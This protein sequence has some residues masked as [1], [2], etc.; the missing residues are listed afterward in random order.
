MKRI[1]LLNIAEKINS[2]AN[3][4]RHKI[5]INES[6]FVNTTELQI[7]IPPLILLGD[8]NIFKYTKSSLGTNTETLKV[9]LDAKNRPQVYTPDFVLL[10]EFIMTKHKS[11]LNGFVEVTHDCGVGF[12]VAISVNDDHVIELQQDCLDG[13]CGEGRPHKKYLKMLPTLNS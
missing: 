10:T 3:P 13:V 1:N 11:G 8:V 2:S 12:T 7:A 4:L 6:A 9:Y 5:G